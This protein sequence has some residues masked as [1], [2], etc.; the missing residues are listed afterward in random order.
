MTSPA[1]DSVLLVS[2]GGPEGPADVEPFLANVTAGRRVPADRLEAVARQ[3]HHFGGISPLNEQ[4]RRLRDALAARLAASGHELPV[5]WG[6]RNWTPY[7]AD[8]VAEMAAA[9]HRRALALVTSAY[10]SYSGCRQYLDDIAA[11]RASAGG[12]AP[13]I[14]KVRAY[15]DHPGFI[16]PFVDAVA[17]ARMNLPAEVRSGARLVFTAHS[18]PESMAA[19]CDYERQLG[20]TARLVAAGAGFDGWTMAWQS[21]SGP[22]SVPWLEPDVNDCLRELSSRGAAA[23]VL[24]PIGFITDHMEVMWDLDVVA[25]GTAADLGLRQARATT[26]GTGPDDRFVAMWQELVEERLDPAKVRRSL[27][28]LGTGPDRCPDSCCPLRT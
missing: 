7:L 13:A 2:F 1:Y 5:Y 9:G 18:I 16:A 3:Y 28:R 21:R 22:P 26:P 17:E 20:E 15:Y 10:S 27:G 4:C 11:A 24:A 25:A 8:A 19:S 6:N 23:V 12:T 14:D